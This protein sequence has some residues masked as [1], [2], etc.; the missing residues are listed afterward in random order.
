MSQ[1]TGICGYATQAGFVIGSFNPGLGTYTPIT[2]NT[3][4]MVANMIPIFLYPKIGRKNM[5]L[6]GNLGIA[7]CNLAVAVLF[8]FATK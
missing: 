5:A 4:Q 6:F 1:M 3:V 7:I 8:I 2:F